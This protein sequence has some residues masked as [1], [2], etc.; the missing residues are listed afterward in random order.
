MN[1]SAVLQF[2]RRRLG[3]YLCTDYLHAPKPFVAA[4]GD[5]YYIFNVVYKKYKHCNSCKKDLKDLL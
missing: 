4:R 3:I 2:M 5:T 1:Y